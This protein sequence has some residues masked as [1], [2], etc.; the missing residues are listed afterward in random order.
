[1]AIKFKIANIN[2][3]IISRIFERLLK[4]PKQLIVKIINN[5]VKYQR[6]PLLKPNITLWKT[7][8]DTEFE[9]KGS[10]LRMYFI[11]KK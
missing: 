5:V 10:I 7:L 2:K 1:M 8:Y 4:Y 11:G 6:C 3:Y 9:T